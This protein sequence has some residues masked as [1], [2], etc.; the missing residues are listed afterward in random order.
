MFKK[1]KKHSD[2]SAYTDHSFIGEQTHIVGDLSFTGGLHLE[3]TVTGNVDSKDGCLH[4]HGEVVGDV[5]VPNAVISGVIRGNVTVHEHL[6]L[7]ADARIEGVVS[8]QRMEMSLGAQV[9]GHLQP[10]V[11]PVLKAVK[12]SAA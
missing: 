2:L 5:E 1:Q 3:G 6:E 10:L 8:Y 11:A 9:T 7:T 12:D 4:L